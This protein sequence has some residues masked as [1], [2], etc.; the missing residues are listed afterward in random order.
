MRPAPFQYIAARSADEARDLLAE[1]QDHARVLAGGQSLIPLMNL[2]MSKPSVLIDLNRC[3]D[4]EY[5]SMKDG[6]VA[7]G[8]MIRQIDAQNSPV[9]SCHCPLVAKA[10][11]LAGPVAVRSRGTI[12]GQIAHADRSAELPV[13]AIA[14]DA[15]VV[16]D[17]AAG[18]REC[19]SATFF[20]DDFTT[21]IRDG[22]M[23]CEVRWPIRPS[24]VFSTF[25]EVGTRQRDMALVSLAAEIELAVDA[26]CTSAKLAVGGVGPIPVRLR[27][28]EAL[29]TDKQI[30]KSVIQSLGEET[31]SAIEATSDLHASADYRRE[32]AG[33]LV[34]Q[35][36]EQ[37]V[38]SRKNNN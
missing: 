15:V 36:L 18:K 22:E 28:I 16:V 26:V 31:R 20:V 5:L 9:I 25:L 27:A 1:H 11:A 12:G 6:Y 10:L 14:L 38:S 30:D 29:L 37:A 24:S 4:L 13:V 2:R 19:S 21:A 23:L 7:V 32:V 3:Q 34:S 8:T 33:A 17:G 35:A